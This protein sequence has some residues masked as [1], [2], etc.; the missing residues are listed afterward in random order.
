MV[1]L[2]LLRR[3]FYWSHI[4]Q[5]QA[6]CVCLLMNTYVHTHA[7]TYMNISVIINTYVCVNKIRYCGWSLLQRALH[8]HAHHTCDVTGSAPT[9]LGTACSTHKGISF[10]LWT[11]TMTQSHDFTFLGQKWIWRPC[12]SIRIFDTD[13]MFTNVNRGGKWMND[14]ERRG[15]QQLPGP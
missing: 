10:Q 9:A 15:W 13:G 3:M 14:Y 5:S 11:C 1:V 8:L 12:R 7:Y 2:T 4:I 6:K